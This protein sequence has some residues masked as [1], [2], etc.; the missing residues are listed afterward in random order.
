MNIIQKIEKEARKHFK[1][2]KS[3]H[4]WEH[5]ERVYNLALHIGK[6]EHANLEILKLAAL[7]HDIAR[8]EE[9]KTGGKIDHA[10]K[11]A[12]LAE[13]ILKNYKVPA[14]KISQITHCIETHRFR[15]KLIPKTKEARTL[16]D[17]DKL[18]AIGAI[19]IGRAF[20]F[21]CEV[22]AKI[23]NKKGTNILKTK[24]YSEEDTAYREFIVKLQKV[25]SRMLT[26][27]GKKLASKRHKFMVEFFTRL[28]KETEGKL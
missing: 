18:D 28:N 6:K 1:G 14:K 22:G 27:E 12:I 3:S 2:K 7:L 13:E 16:F 11:G 21:A 17:A 25:K 26:R 8:H 15:G 19:G 5:T 9:D 20:F 10:K 24:E 23:H 4:D